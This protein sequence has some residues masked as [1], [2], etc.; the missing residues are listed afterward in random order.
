[1]DFM[2]KALGL[3]KK[4]NPYPNPKVGAVLVKDGKVIG[5]GY[6]RKPGKPH[7]EIEAINDAKKKGHSVR[8]ATLYVTLEPCSHKNKR[9]P[10]CTEA[11]VKNR[12]SRVVF[13][14]KDPN[15]LVRGAKILE[16]HGV[17]V[18]G[19]VAQKKAEKINKRYL[20]LAMRKPFV[21]IKMALSADG[22][23]ATRS[24]DSRWISCPESR[25]FVHK[26]RAEYDAVM[27]GAGTVRNDNPRLTARIR[28]AKDPLRVIVDGRLSIPLDSKVVRKGTII[29]VSEKAPKKK[30][31]EAVKK[32]A[33]VFV[34]GKDMVGIR[35]L[36]SN[37]GMMG[38]RRILIEGGSGLNASALE[39]GVV[40]RL[41]LFVAPKIIGGR[42]ARGVV[43][44]LGA[45]TMKNALEAKKMTSRRSGRD[46]LLILEL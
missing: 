21:A 5:Q 38:V 9:T 45:K 24:G 36:V 25:E 11:I 1:M 31:L 13:G 46:I 34:S 8:G 6:H 7:A 42:E 26:L 17:A 10:P 41:Y 33:A 32:G 28:G 18:R 43:G 37:L 4:A 19:P 2:E 20:E 29:A 22:K 30:V 16:R 27:V 40:D 23:T 44:G 15:P 12:I 39:A 35:E 14:M 3:A